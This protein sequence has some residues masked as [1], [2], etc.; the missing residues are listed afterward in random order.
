MKKIILIVAMFIASFL[1]TNPALSKPHENNNNIQINNTQHTKKVIKKK[2]YT[3]RIEKVIEKPQVQPVTTYD[4]ETVSGFWAAER[5]RSLKGLASKQN[6]SKPIQSSTRSNDDNDLVGKAQQY[7]GSTASQ[8]G[9]PRTLWCADFMNM[10]VG[11]SDRSAAS[12]LKRG[13]AAPHGCVNC[14]AVTT[15]RG[16]NHVGVV[17]GYEDGN[18]IIISGN[19]LGRV[20]VG[21]YRRERVIGYRTL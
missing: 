19:H 21:V 3:K 9:L 15:R 20:G 10:L 14:V 11:G 16:G 13:K 7:M 18:P 12:Y 6:E 4:E 1:L 8:L 17:A 2:K 5:A